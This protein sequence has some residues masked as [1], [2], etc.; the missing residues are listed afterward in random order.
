ML[1]NDV[2]DLRDFYASPLGRLVRRHLGRCIRARWRRLD[3]A[4]LV[5]LGFAT[6]FLGTYR[7]EAARIAALMP[8]CQGALVWPPAGPVMSVLVDEDRLPLP[9]NSVDRLLAVHCLE[10]ADRVRPLLREMWRVLAP[11]GKLLIVVPNRRGVWARIDTT[12]FGQG[13]PYSRTQL[14]T[15][16]N[17]SMF[18]PLECS[19]ALFLPPVGFRMALRAAPFFEKAG[20]SV[21]PGFAGVLLMEA[22]KE[23]MMP[24]GT[25]AKAR[26]LTRLLPVSAN[27]KQVTPEPLAEAARDAGVDGLSAALH[28]R[29]ALKLMLPAALLC[30]YP[31]K[32]RADELS[33]GAFKREVMALLRRE[34]PALDVRD[35]DDADLIGIGSSKVGLANLF[36]R[37][38]DLTG[39]PREAE[40]VRFLD[41]LPAAGTAAGTTTYATFAEVA[42]ALRIQ[43]APREYLRQSA[44]GDLSFPHRPLSPYVVAAYA[45]DESDRLQYVT[46]KHLAQWHVDAAALHARSL[47]NLEDASRDI[48]INVRK[49]SAGRGAF[50]TLPIRDGYGAARLLCPGFMARLETELG[51]PFFAGIPNREFLIA[52]SADFGARTRFAQQIAKDFASE[53]YPLSP[54]I[55]A[56]ESGAVRLASAAELADHG[57]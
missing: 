52:W 28:R 42:P 40:I 7:R 22:T 11:G 4:T 10:V 30:G 16:L 9:D 14:E 34:R 50:A 25:P 35:T 54:E 49:A 5:G 39:H 23:V 47:A 32:A 13:R 1:Q 8:A 36:R 19:R 44:Q 31:L 26:R 21:T 46:D 3:G 41:S 15:L 17:D 24:V 51:A 57:R 55:F 45:I 48:A 53:P 56:F 29:D 18:T 6:P 38:R 37:V 2:V 20:A 43:I 33:S 12:P 27:K